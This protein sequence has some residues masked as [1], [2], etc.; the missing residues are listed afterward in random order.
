MLPKTKNINAA[1]EYF[2]RRHLYVGGKFL[3]STTLSQL[4]PPSSCLESC[5]S[6][7]VFL[8]LLSWA[9]V[10]RNVAFCYN[11]ISTSSLHFARRQKSFGSMF[12]TF[13]DVE[14][15]FQE[16]ESVRTGAKELRFRCV[17]N[18]ICLYVF[19]IVC[20]KIRSKKWK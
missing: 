19:R 18:F 7:Y 9:L 4:F 10:I 5:N 6:I 3:T 8:R 15:L 2:G 16:R 13:F 20:W 14:V 1:T 17:F 12:R 11:Y